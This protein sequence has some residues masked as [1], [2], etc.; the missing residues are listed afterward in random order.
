LQQDWVPSAEVFVDLGLEAP[1]SPTLSV[2]YDFDAGTGTYTTLGLSHEVR[3][4]LTLAVNLFH[5]SHYYGASGIPA[6]EVK[7]S[8]SFPLG[9]AS[10]SPSLSRF[11]TWDNGDFAGSAAVPSNW[12]FAINVSGTR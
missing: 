11:V 7:A 9:V 3:A 10:I 4:P 6:L 2:H 12:L 1:F 8:A 5:Q